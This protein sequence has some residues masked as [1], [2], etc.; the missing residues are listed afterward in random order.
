MLRTEIISLSKRNLEDCI[1]ID[2]ITH[3]RLWTDSQWEYELSS[4]TRIC[5][6]I[7]LKSRVVA[8]ICGS[9]TRDELE[10]TFLAVRPEYQRQGFASKLLSSL[11]NQ[12]KRKSLKRA[13]LEVKSINF[14]ALNL[15]KNFYFEK[16]NVRKKYYKDGSDAFIFAV[17]I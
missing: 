4:H 14:P 17:K 7:N 2:K 8:L 3:N 12:A 15:Y 10:I 16:I 9:I 13:I 6:G 5:I 11:L 1:E